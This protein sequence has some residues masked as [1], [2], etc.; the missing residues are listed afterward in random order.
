MS[1]NKS[2]VEHA[3]RESFSERGSAIGHA[4]Q[5]APSEPAA[6]RDSFGEA[7]LLRCLREAMHRL[8]FFPIPSCRC[9]K[10]WSV[11]VGWKAVYA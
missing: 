7:V 5:L 3:G 4:P 11:A 8:I 10:P 1:I 2:S 6:E 9:S